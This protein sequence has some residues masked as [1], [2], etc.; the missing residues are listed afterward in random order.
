MFRG[1]FRDDVFG[2]GA[3][4]PIARIDRH[5]DLFNTPSARESAYAVLRS[6]LDTRPVVARLSRI[7]TPTLVVWGVDDRLFPA[8]FANRL[9]REIHGAT[10]EIMDTGHS[11]HE[12]RPRDFAYLV[13]EFLE[14]KR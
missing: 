1:Y 13:S 8:A 7:T 5:Y 10:L 4:L 11:P 14:G 6:I 12:E 9:A 2:R 3:E